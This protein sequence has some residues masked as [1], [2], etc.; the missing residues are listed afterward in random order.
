MPLCKGR[1][2]ESDPGA[3]KGAPRESAA[4]DL[5]KLRAE[6]RR[7]CVEVSYVHDLSTHAISVFITFV[8]QARA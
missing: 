7:R 8:Y 5:R 1:W 2:I 4:S 3:S 6:G